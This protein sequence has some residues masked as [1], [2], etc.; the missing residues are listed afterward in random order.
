MS[1]YGGYGSYARRV[2]VSGYGRYGSY[3]RRVMVFPMLF[4]ILFFYPVL[5]RPL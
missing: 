1:G 2:V 3:A 5:Y 4:L